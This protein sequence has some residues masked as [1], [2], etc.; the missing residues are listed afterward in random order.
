MKKLKKIIIILIICDISILAMLIFTLN[1]LKEENDVNEKNNNTEAKSI[2]QVFDEANKIEKIDTKSDYF[3]VKKC[4][5]KYSTCSNYL[6]YAQLE[7]TIP[8]NEKNNIESNKKQLLN[9]VP[10]FVIQKLNLQESNVYNE[11]GLPNKYIRIEDIYV[12]KQTINKEAN[13][14]TTDINAYFVNGVFIDKNNL[15]KEEFNIIFIIDR[16]NGTFYILPQKYIEQENITFEEGSNLRLYEDEAIENNKFNKVDISTETDQQM[17]EEYI[18]RFRLNLTYD[19]EYIYNSFDE[20]YRNKRF[21]T[22]EN[23]VRY[24]NDNK[25]ELNKI[26]L[27]SYLTNYNNDENYVEY[28]CKDQYENLYIFKQTSPMDFTLR[29][30]TYT[31]ETEKFKETYESA[32]DVQ[33]VQMN[34][35]KFFQMI[36]RHDYRT[37]YEC[38]AQS[39]KNNYFKTETEFADFVKNNMFSRNK[40]TYKNYEQRGKD[41]YVFNIELTDLIGEN[42]EIK[43]VTIVMQLNENLDFNMSFSM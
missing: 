26:K 31:I 4:I 32:D 34:I 18:N 8:E 10:D 13:K 7:D 14:E 2:E 27:N 36:N 43:K 25:V 9:L 35:D 23:F 42:T 15:N 1:K 41:L 16:V 33:K 30:D 12:S 17:S 29:I 5:D 28:V 37:S 21:G 3:S 20:E 24:I 22:Y 40:V 38:L 6:Y 19:P 11:I 39:Y